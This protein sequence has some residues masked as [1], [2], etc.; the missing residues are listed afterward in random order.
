MEDRPQEAIFRPALILM[1]GRLL[2][3]VA[4]FLIPVVLARLLPQ[5]AFG[6][7]K[8]LFLIFGTLFGIAQV[9]M[10]ESLFYFLPNE[11]RHAGRYVANTLAVL[12]L[13][14]GAAA[15]ALA[16]LRV[17]LADLLNNPAMA[18]YL[19]WLGL[20]FL[21]M[22]LSVLLEILMTVRK[23]HVL[24]SGTY[25]VSDVVRAV[26][27]VLPVL[28][29]GELAWLLAGAVGFALGRALVA[30]A[31]VWR[32]FG[33]LRV[34]RALLTR[35]LAYALP[36]GL[37][38]MI[39][40]LQ[41]NYHLYAV[42]YYFTP[43]VF[44]IY[45]VGCL[46]VPL[47]DLLTSTSSNVMMI[48]M[49]EKML[50]GQPSQA[51]SIWLDTIR[52]IALVMCPLIALMLLTAPEL[53]VLLFTDA[54]A[55]SVPIFMI[56]MLTV[57]FAVLLTDGALRVAAETRFLILLNAVQ[58]LLIVLG[59]R[60]FIQGFGLIGAVLVTL[61]VTVVSKFLALWRIRR[62][63]GVAIA[64][65]LP[66]QALS[67]SLLLSAGALLPAWALKNLFELPPLLSLASS[68]AVF[69][70]SYTGLLLHWGP[71]H[72]DEKRQVLEWISAPL[73]RTKLRTR[74]T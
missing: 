21:L 66:W 67:A 8:Q 64:R 65:L 39:E 33:S 28:L 68:A 44:A 24:A 30:I 29:F 51:W 57:L 36:F 32:E 41:V 52:K 63:Y 61:A 12:G 5:E 40:M 54:Y 46:Q 70:L 26:L 9:G 16:L 4:A 34:D 19:P 71:L 43:A 42:S 72:E 37:A 25:A 22:L 50:D 15:L 7:Y 60:W 27:L 55:D 17:P 45:A 31:Y 53:I 2:G 6:S 56:W 14:G 62:V 38:G 13:A 1:S 74:R 35:Q 69:I 49:R 10:A 18:A 11:R 20:F 73:G 48:Q 59:I 23:Q 58:L 3:F 47:F